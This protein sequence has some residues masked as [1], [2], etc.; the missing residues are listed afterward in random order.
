MAT[1]NCTVRFYKDSDANPNH[2]YKDYNGPYHNDEIGSDWVDA[3]GDVNADAS[4]L[5]TGSKGWIQLFDQQGCVGNSVVFNNNTSIAN[6]NTRKRGD[7][8]WDNQVRSFILQD[9]PFGDVEAIQNH[10]FKGFADFYGSTTYGAHYEMENGGNHIRIYSQ[11]GHF[12]ID[13]PTITAT[14]GSTTMN[15]HLYV[16]HLKDGGDDHCTIDFSMDNSGRVVGDSFSIVY[17][18]SSAR[19]VPDWV[20]KLADLCIDGAEEALK[21]AVDCSEEVITEGLGTAAVPITNKV[22]GYAADALTFTV[23]HVNFLLKLKF[24]AEENGGT[25]FFTSIVAQSIHRLMTAYVK[26]CVGDGSIAINVGSDT[27][28]EL[29]LDYNAM[30]TN[31]LGSGHTWDTRVGANNYVKEIDLSGTSYNYDVWMPDYSPGLMKTGLLVSFKIDS[32]ISGGNDYAAINILFAPDKSIMALQGSVLYH[33]ATKEIKDDDNWSPPGTGMIAWQTDS[34]GHRKLV[35][36]TQD[37]DNHTQSK[38]LTETN[39]YTAYQN[40]FNASFDLTKNETN[41]D[42][43]TLNLPKAS[44]AVIDAI[45]KSIIVGTASDSISFVMTAYTGQMSTGQKLLP[46]NSLVS[47]S[48]QY[49]LIYQTDGNLC[50]YN[51]STCTWATNTQSHSAGYAI[52]GSD[53]HLA[54]YDASGERVWYSSNW[55]NSTANKLS[56]QDDGNLVIY[57]N[58]AA[59]WASN[60]QYK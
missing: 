53:G 17:D 34:N 14:P 42:G 3:V 11:N 57:A 43:G 28:S 8:T 7:K 12:Q 27:N 29:K 9:Y 25:I 50:I 20:I 46:N 39:I 21:I 36:L 51:D 45:S 48:G 15:F 13:K 4:A 55:N 24:K 38:D 10:F 1:P 30:M 23:D 33:N 2:G 44:L 49:K 37:A 26:T 52:F 59:C 32:K 22:I 18:M 16:T 58:T 19:Q 60:T 6:L 5:S 54:V 35:Q 41:Y 31:M 47:N 40:C 56:M